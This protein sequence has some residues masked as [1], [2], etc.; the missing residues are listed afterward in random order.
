MDTILPKTTPDDMD[1]D[2]LLS[3]LGVEITSESEIIKLTHV[4]TRAEK[5]AAEEIE[6]RTPCIDFEIFKPLFIQIQAE[7]K[8][9]VRKSL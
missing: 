2:A 5:K 1:D 4:K 8:A 6:Q 9:S 7:L 3:E